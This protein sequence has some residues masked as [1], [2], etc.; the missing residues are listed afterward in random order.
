M[1][2]YESDLTKFMRE[3]LEQHPEEVESQRTG[4]AIWWDKKPEDRSPTPSMRHAPRSGG[5]E[6]S[7][8]PAGGFEW[9]FGADDDTSGAS[10]DSNGK[11]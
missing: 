5:A 6:H 10:D 3:F 2:G 9:S 11:S 1:P 4:R 8:E 7:F